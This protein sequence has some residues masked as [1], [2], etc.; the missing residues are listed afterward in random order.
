MRLHAQASLPRDSVAAYAAD[1][2]E[3]TTDTDGY[4]LGPDGERGVTVL[5]SDGPTV[6]TNFSWRVNVSAPSIGSRS[7]NILVPQG[8][9]TGLFD[10]VPVPPNI[11]D[12]ILEWQQLR[13]DVYAARDAARGAQ[14]LAE[15]AA[16]A[17]ALD[18]GRAEV[19]A[20]DAEASADI[21]LR[22]GVSA[23]LGGI[24]GTL[25]LHFSALAA[26]PFP[27]TVLVPIRKD[28]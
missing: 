23:T 21:A 11:G 28:A 24:P 7:W 3:C 5:A 19:A 25:A 18:A 14:G 2:I 22:M 6:P 8:E 9:T 26:G 27:L 4:L 10:A 12:A 13:D 17:A 20:G 15:D 1:T 16:E